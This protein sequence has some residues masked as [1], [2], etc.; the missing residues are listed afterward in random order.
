MDNATRLTSRGTGEKLYFGDKEGWSL[1]YESGAFIIR[2]ETG[3]DDLISIDDA[4][5]AIEF[6]RSLGTSKNPIPGTTHFEEVKVNRQTINSSLD[7][8]ELSISNDLDN[9]TSIVEHGDMNGDSLDRVAVVSVPADNTETG[10]IDVG[11]PPGVLLFVNGID[12]TQDNRQ[13]VDI[14]LFATLGSHTVIGSDERNNPGSRTYGALT[15][16]PPSIAIDD[17]GTTY[18]IFCRAIGF[19][20]SR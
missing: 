19:L 16:G 4:G 13:F 10:L 17:S 9:P 14:I 3:D 12:Q 1:R 20:T 6:A 8:T 18:D 7:A 2:D 11:N 15:G 5:D